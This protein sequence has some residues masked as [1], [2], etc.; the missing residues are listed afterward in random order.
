MDF[1][2]SEPLM[3]KYGISLEQINA[4]KALAAKLPSDVVDGTRM[5]LPRIPGLSAFESELLIERMLDVV[6]P[7]FGVDVEGGELLDLAGYPNMIELMAVAERQAADA[8]LT[9]G[10]EKPHLHV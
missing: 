2:I 1:S 8:H 10:S 7:V 6:A 3:L 4:L 5:S 9:S